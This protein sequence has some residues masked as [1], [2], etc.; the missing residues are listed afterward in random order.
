MQGG[1][2]ARDVPWHGRP[3][4]RGRTGSRRAPGRRCGGPACQARTQGPWRSSRPAQARGWQEPVADR[5]ASKRQTSPW[6]TRSTPRNRFGDPCHGPLGSAKA[7]QRR[8]PQNCQEQ[9]WEDRFGDVTLFFAL[10]N[11][12]DVPFRR[13]L[14]GASNATGSPKNGADS[15]QGRVAFSM[16]TGSTGTSSWTPTDCVWTSAMR[17]TTSMPSMTRP[18]TQ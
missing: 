9:R 2:A 10:T 13:L 3:V 12:P 8:L 16:R 15:D 6:E 18:K 14:R 1:L 11:R 5:T 7:L 4:V 17:S